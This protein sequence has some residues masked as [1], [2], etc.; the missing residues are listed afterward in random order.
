LL[1]YFLCGGGGGLGKRLKW[2][3]CILHKRRPVI[4][5]KPGQ[6]MSWEREIPKYQQG[7]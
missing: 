1:W 3:V 7:S 5:I 2:V 6:S 4:D